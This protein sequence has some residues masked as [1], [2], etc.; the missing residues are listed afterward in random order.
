[1]VDRKV[2]IGCKNPCCNNPISPIKRRNNN[3]GISEYCTR[4][5]YYTWSP[6][7]DL[8]FRNLIRLKGVKGAVSDPQEFMKNTIQEVLGRF[9]TWTARAALLRIKRQTF[10]RWVK[11][12]KA[13]TPKL[14]VE[15]Q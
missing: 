7:M 1:M 14:K 5:C 13:E 2:S 10:I 9:P 15:R 8:V 6:G 3:K 4:K 12:F 11:H